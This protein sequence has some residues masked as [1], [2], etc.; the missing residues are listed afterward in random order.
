V[1]NASETPAAT[2]AGVE[3][4]LSA[5]S[6]NALMIPRTVPN[7]PTNGAIT[8]IVPIA[9]QRVEVLHQ[10]DRK[11]VGDVGTILLAALETE[12]ENAWQHAFLAGADLNR[13]RQIVIGDALP[14]LFEQAFGVAVLRGKE[15][16]ALDGDRDADD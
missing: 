4:P 9:F 13:A 6:W 1:I 11:R 2:T 12:L 10:R 5:M 3:L 15:Y 16:Q 14:N 8:A 7:S